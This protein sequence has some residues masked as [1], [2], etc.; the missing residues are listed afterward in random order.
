MRKK[1]PDRHMYTRRHKSYCALSNRMYSN[2][3]SLLSHLELQTTH[4]QRKPAVS[5]PGRLIRSETPRQIWEIAIE[6][7]EQKQNNT[8]AM[9]SKESK[10]IRET[11]KQTK[12]NLQLNREL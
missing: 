3:N 6:H 4:G 1:H 12:R 9:G 10:H 2:V 5:H 11:R 7:S 8:S